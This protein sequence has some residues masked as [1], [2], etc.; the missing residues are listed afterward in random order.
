MIEAIRCFDDSYID[1]NQSEI[2]IQ[3][4]P[5]YEVKEG[6]GSQTTFKGLVSKFTPKYS[7][8]LKPEY[9]FKKVIQMINYYRFVCKY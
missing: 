3:S 9:D 8:Y 2:I 5:V 4:F 7:K 1:L 6:K